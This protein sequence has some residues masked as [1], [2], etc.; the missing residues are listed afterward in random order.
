MARSIRIVV[1]LLMLPAIAACSGGGDS[2]PEVD[3]PSTSTTAV[4]S[5]STTADD[6]GST[7]SV[8]TTIADQ[9]GEEAVADALQELAGRFD[10]AVAG[11][12]VDPRVA[13]DSDHPAV[14]D[15]LDLFVPDSQFASGALEAWA[16]E[17]AQGRFYRPGP[18]GRMSES[19]V[20]DVVLDGEDAATF[21]MC[22]IRSVEIVDAAG[23]PV[24][25]D[26]GTSAATGVAQQVRAG[27]LLRE[28]SETSPDGCEP[29][30][31]GESAP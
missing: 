19:T 8:P 12:L 3:A 4:E 6:E 14:R 23:H 30:D 18:R 26:G 17:G 22:S 24:S 20:I 11:I 5:S 9:T 21:T 16:R 7:T 25:G 1:G 10:E 15:Y 28:L 31:D 29:A 13:A 27:W 2:D